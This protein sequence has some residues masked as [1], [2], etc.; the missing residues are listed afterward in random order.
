[1]LKEILLD[2][3][4]NPPSQELKDEVSKELETFVKTFVHKDQPRI[5][6]FV[7]INLI[8]FGLG[9]LA[10]MDINEDHKRVEKLNCKIDPFKEFEHL[11]K[12]NHYLMGL[13]QEMWA[14]HNR[15]LA[16]QLVKGK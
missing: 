5:Q 13:L 12:D 8:N 2:S 9:I 11:A 6:S 3:A 1:M 14:K 10:A 15:D 4:N 7:A 16:I